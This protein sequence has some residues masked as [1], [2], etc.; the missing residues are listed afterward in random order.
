[1]YENDDPLF[2]SLDAIKG[3]NAF[4]NSFLHSKIRLSLRFATSSIRYD[5][6]T[7]STASTAGS[8]NLT[9]GSALPAAAP[10]ATSSSAFFAAAAAFLSFFFLFLTV[11]EDTLITGYLIMSLLDDQDSR[12]ISTSVVEGVY[13]R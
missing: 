8:D 10:S 7:Q 3:S 11:A 6:S 5:K 9:S 13:E 12:E 1:V 2:R 4:Q